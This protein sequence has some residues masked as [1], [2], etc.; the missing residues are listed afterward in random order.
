VFYW[1]EIRFIANFEST[2]FFST[3]V[4]NSIRIMETLLATTATPQYLVEILQ[5]HHS[6]IVRALP[7]KRKA[8]AWID[9]MIDT[10]FPVRCLE[11]VT[12]LEIRHLELQLLELLM[13]IEA[14]LKQPM[15]VISRQFFAQI[16]LIYNKLK[17]DAEAF[18]AFDPAAHSIEEVVAAYPGFY[19][20]AVYRFSHELYLLKVPI[21]PRLI[22]EWAHSQ[23]GIDINPGA[24]IGNSFFID[25]GTGVVIGETCEIGDF[26][27][28]YQGV[29]L[30]AL[31]VKK[32]L[33]NK[34]RHPTIEDNVVIYSGATILGGTTV[35]G[36]N[37][38]IGGNVFLTHSVAPNS[39]VYQ[40]MEIKVRANRDFE[41][42]IDFVI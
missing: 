12:E 6:Q 42:P 3:L 11:P 33:S 28:I 8:Q 31:Q 35:I 16:P 10:L 15:E 34:K 39:L 23:T 4:Y 13:P 2:H 26:V 21:L 17:R 19:A 24:T 37:A 27:K 20:I 5:E 32:E 7:N 36:E 30:G 1:L 40:K 41:E 14:E 9:R 18:L 38:V 22:S 29:T 25:H